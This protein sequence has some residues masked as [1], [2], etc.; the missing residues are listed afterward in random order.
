MFLRN[1]VL[2][3][4]GLSCITSHIHSWVMFLL[5]LCLLIL[6]GVSFPLISSSTLGTYSPGEFIFQCHIFLPFHPVHGVLKA[7]MLKCFAV[8][9]SSGHVLSELS[10]MTRS[11]S[12]ALLSMAHS[13]IDLDKAVIHVISLVSFL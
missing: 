2:Y 6:S 1:I 9:F 3:S 13:F 8:P 7:R 5:C 4:I 11:S 12:G 10:T